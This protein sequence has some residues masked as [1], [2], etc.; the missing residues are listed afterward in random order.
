MPVSSTAAIANLSAFWY[1]ASATAS[2]TRCVR[3]RSRSA[4]AVAAQR[5]A[6][7]HHPGARRS[8]RVGSGGVDEC[9]HAGRLLRAE[10]ESASAWPIATAVR[11]STSSTMSGPS[12]MPGL[13]CSTRGSSVEKIA[14]TPFS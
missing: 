7:E 12:R 10:P 9:A 2:T 4:N 6:T 13:N 5:R 14:H 11:S 8:R 3:S 1:A